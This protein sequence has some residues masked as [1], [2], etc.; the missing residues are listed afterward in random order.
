MSTPTQGAG[1]QVIMTWL[2]GIIGMITG[3]TGMVM[4]FLGRKHQNNES[5]LAYFSSDGNPRY[6][7]ARYFIY[8]MNEGAII[9][10]KYEEA[11][12]KHV[13]MITNMFHKWGLLVKHKHLP[14]WVFV[15]S[16]KIT[17]S[18][19]AVVRLY[20]KLRPT[21]KYFKEKNDSYA[22]YFTYLYDRIIEKQ[23]SYLDYK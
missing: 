1:L 6:I 11:A 13:S 22:E 2:P 20:N 3:I 7:E 19:L 18:G 12:R 4:N 23:P 9:D 15:D 10:E 16:G 14:F 17:A 8:N 21:I 5:V